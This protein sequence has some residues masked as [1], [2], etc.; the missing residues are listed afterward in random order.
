MLFR[1]LQMIW[2]SVMCP[3]FS[4]GSGRRSL[5]GQAGTVLLYLRMLMPWHLSVPPWYVV[6]TGQYP[7]RT[8]QKNGVRTARSNRIAE[9]RTGDQLFRQGPIGTDLS[10]ESCLP[11][12]HQN[13]LNHITSREREKQPF[14]LYVPRRMPYAPILPEKRF[15]GQSGFDGYGD[16]VSMLND[17]VGQ[18]RQAIEDAEFS[19]NTTSVFSLEPDC[20]PIFFEYLK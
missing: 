11:I 10:P 3:I 13:N 8:F 17:L 19:D 6:I 9:E 4:P 18:I 15:S 20:N 1:L 16:F 12:M 7:F 2:A 14:S 5:N